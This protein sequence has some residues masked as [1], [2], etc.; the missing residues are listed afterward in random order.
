MSGPILTGNK[1]NQNTDQLESRPN[2]TLTDTSAEN[3][4]DLPAALVRQGLYAEAVLK[5]GTMVAT[6]G[7]NA[8]PGEP[9]GHT[10]SGEENNPYG[11]SQKS[12][13]DQ[14]QDGLKGIEGKYAGTIGAEIAIQ[15]DE[16]K[17]REREEDVY[18]AALLAEAGRYA[19]MSWKELE[20]EFEQRLNPRCDHALRAH[21]EAVDLAEKVEEQ[22]QRE[23]DEREAQIKVKEDELTQ[24]QDRLATLKADPSADPNAVARLEDEIKAKKEALALMRIDND[25]ASTEQE[26]LLVLVRRAEREADNLREKRDEIA[27]KLLDAKEGRIQITEEERKELAIK[28]NGLEKRIGNLEQRTQYLVTHSREAMAQSDQRRAQWQEMKALADRAEAGEQLTEQEQARLAEFKERRA[29]RESHHGTGNSAGY[30]TPEER[31]QLDALD[32][33]LATLRTSRDTAAASWSSSISGVAKNELSRDTASAIKDLG[34]ETTITKEQLTALAQKYGTEEIALGAE[35]SKKGITVADTTTDYTTFDFDKYLNERYPLF[36]GGTTT[37]PKTPI[38]D[39][40][41][42]SLNPSFGISGGGYSSFADS[43]DFAKTNPTDPGLLATAS[44]AKPWGS[45]TLTAWDT[46][47]SFLDSAYGLSSTTPVTPTSPADQLRLGNTMLAQNNQTPV[48]RN[49]GTVV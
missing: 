46:T 42:F 45:P 24:L 4:D 7:A 10:L 48:T 23:K 44:Y 2:M 1:N 13:F 37:Y 9:E 22:I 47:S 29:S 32:K 34:S 3:R 30:M 43:L 26:K 49:S 25:I 19:F 8:K 11:M 28:M 39:A 33:R 15:N 17:Q 20:E 12:T 5:A 14:I 16:K 38:L 18:I 6:L 21:S 36:A 31:A 27:Q 40:S 35:L 41:N